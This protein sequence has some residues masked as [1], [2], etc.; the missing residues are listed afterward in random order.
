MDATR[1]LKQQLGPIVDQLINMTGTARDAFNRHRR[2]CLIDLNQ[3][4]ETFTQKINAA[5]GQV[6]G[7]LSR[8][9]GS[10]KTTLL[11]LHSIL[12][13]LNAIGDNL[14]R[15]AEPLQKKIQEAVLFSDKA[16]AQTNYLFD[17]Q[18]GILR[19]LVDIVHTDNQFLKKYVVEEGQKM[20]QACLEFATEHEARLIEGLCLPQAGPIFLAILDRMQT[21]TQHELEIAG[22]LTKKS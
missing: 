20:R 4:H 5:I 14:A 7:L 16:V 22:L 19:S 18:V 11:Q 13:H 12:S 10:E 8:A 9:S 6:E 15:L 21:I 17:H 3:Q 2:Q 1:E